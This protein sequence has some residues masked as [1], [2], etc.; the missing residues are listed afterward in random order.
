MRAVGDIARVDTTRLVALKE[1]RAANGLRKVED[2]V[3]MKA[4]MKKVR[5]LC[6]LV[7]QI[8]YYM[9][10]H[11]PLFRPMQSRGPSW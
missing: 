8:L 3:Q 9:T 7:F 4:K 5:V 10:T 11:T 2:P 1:R 6:D